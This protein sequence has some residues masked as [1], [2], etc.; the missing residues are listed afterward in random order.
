MTMRPFIVRLI[1]LVFAVLCG[2]A[3]TEVKKSK[4]I[5]SANELT[6]VIS[7]LDDP[8]TKMPA[9]KKLVRFASNNLY[10][11]SMIHASND[12]AQDEL[13]RT[14]GRAVRAH[15]DMETI[16]A[17]L[18]DEDRSLR[19]W[20]V[21]GFEILYG[22]RAAWLPL[23]PR[24]MDVAAKD[25]DA[26][27]RFEAIRKLQYYDEARENL[28]RLWGAK[29]EKNFNVVM[30]L[31][32][33]GSGSREKFY[34]RAVELLSD[35]DEAVRSHWLIYTYLNASNSATAPMW[36]IEPN[37]DLIKKLED[38]QMNGLPKEQEL[39]AKALNALRDNPAARKIATDRTGSANPK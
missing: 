12:P 26:G 17:A 8:A 33:F 32:G 13:R 19:L 35:P 30:M 25:A 36:R 18:Q 24:L 9:L 29:Q 16:G 22:K 5:Q 31:S 34:A 39:A 4:E 21:M 37:P 27:I 2:F 3:Q 10:E 38:I 11:T 20:G 7:Q 28:A 1:A 6:Q 14:A 23:L 15:K